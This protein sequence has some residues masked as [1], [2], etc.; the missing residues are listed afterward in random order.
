MAKK[1]P[2]KPAR[3]R[4]GKFERSKYDRDRSPVDSVIDWFREENDRTQEEGVVEWEH[5]DES[6]TKS[7]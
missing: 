4:D 5:S 6:D 7:K 2:K 3:T 1:N